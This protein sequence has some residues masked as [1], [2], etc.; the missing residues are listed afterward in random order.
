MSICSRGIDGHP[1]GV[2]IRFPQKTSL[3]VG[4]DGIACTTYRRWPFSALFARSLGCRF[5]WPWMPADI[6]PVAA[7]EV[8]PA[9]T[10]VAH[11][12]RS[13]GYKKHDQT[14]PRREII[15]ALRAKLTI[16]EAVPDLAQSA[17]LVDAAVCVLAGDDFIARRAMNPEN[18]S[19]AEREGWIWTAAPK[20]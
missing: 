8:Y 15:E 12:I 6:S 14:D 11:R 10:L 9:D 13:T 17:D 1:T 3:D 16:G 19:L 5:R 20:T 18:R 4:V 7:I 2:P